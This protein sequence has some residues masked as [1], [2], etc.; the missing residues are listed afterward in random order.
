MRLGGVGWDKGRKVLTV[1][2]P[3][4]PASVRILEVFLCFFAE[5]PMAEINRFLIPREASM[6]PGE[7]P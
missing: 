4:E 7:N 1:W 3:R 5:T 2:W 6:M